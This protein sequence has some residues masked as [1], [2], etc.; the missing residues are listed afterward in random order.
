MVQLV[1]GLLCKHEDLTLHPQH[2]H[3]TEAQQHVLVIP[4]LERR[5]QEDAGASQPTSLDK[6]V[7]CRFNVTSIIKVMEQHTQHSGGRT[8]A[9]E[10]GMR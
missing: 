7:S 2:P 6:L 9:G 3:R 1:Q 5:R 10:E 8:L 4:A